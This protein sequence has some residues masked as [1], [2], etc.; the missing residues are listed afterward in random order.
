MECER[1]PTSIL[2]R[3]SSKKSL[4]NLLRLTT[5]WSVEDEEEAARERRRRERERQQQDGSEDG[6][7]GE[8]VTD[9]T[10]P[11]T[12]DRVGLKPGG[13]MECEE[14]EGFSDWSQQKKLQEAFQATEETGEARAAEKEGS[15]SP[16]VKKDESDEAPISREEEEEDEGT[17]RYEVTELS[18]EPDPCNCERR[19]P[20]PCEQDEQNFQSHQWATSN[21]ESH[22]HEETLEDEPKSPEVPEETNA[23]YSGY[24]SSKQQDQSETPRE[25]EA[26]EA[27][28]RRLSVSSDGESEGTIATTV[29]LTERTECLNRSIQKSNSIKK[30]E[31]PLPISKIDDRL[32]QY[33]HAI[34]TSGKQP[35]LTRTPSLELLSPIDAVS[36]K[37]NRWET[38]DVTSASKS[39]PSKD[40]EGIAIGVSEMISQWGKGKPEDTAQSP[41]KPAEVRPGDV[42]SKKNLWE[43]T[44]KSDQSGKS[45]SASKKYKFVLAG[46]GKY[47]KVYVEDP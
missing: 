25:W 26:E 10:C 22:V 24:Y 2:R 3:N 42:L 12:D 18:D 47:E 29:K 43:Q 33:T 4:Q 38:G 27:A 23:E 14:D 17:S 30:S 5:Q 31:P 34:E 1:V 35:K 9:A 20:E 8:G 44:T 11:E 41:S 45:L 28:D 36:A 19:S 15:D 46:H 21:S 13:P 16:T 7:T 40:T 32:E 6:E 39:T 37:K